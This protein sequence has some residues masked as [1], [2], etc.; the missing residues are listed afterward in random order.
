M[1]IQMC[2]R[3]KAGAVDFRQNRIGWR[4]A[5]RGISIISQDLKPDFAQIVC[6]LSLQQMWLAERKRLGRGA[7]SVSIGCRETL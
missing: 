4:C 3:E 7:K 2:V 1:L 5:A 6:Q